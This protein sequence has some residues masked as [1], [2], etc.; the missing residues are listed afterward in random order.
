MK[1]SD[2]YYPI[3][4][5]FES[6]GC[7]VEGEVKSCDVIVKMEEE[8]LAIEMKQ[9]LNFK[10][11]LQAVQRQKMF[12]LVYIAIPIKKINQA[13]RI[14]REKIHLLK[15]L[16]LGLLL[17]EPKTVV[18][19]CVQQPIESNQRQI[20]SANKKRKE[21][22]IQEFEKRIL[23]N[24]IG[25][26]HQQKINTYYRQ[27]CCQVAYYLKEKPNSAVGLM[28][29][30]LERKR[31]HQILY[32]NHYGW[33]ER[34]E[35]RGNYQLSELGREMVKNNQEMLQKLVSESEAKTDSLET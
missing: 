32:D 16:G 34:T 17:I 3:K 10:V 4:N 7:T 18:V 35:I 19:T 28:K 30:G 26:V 25:G 23:K 6:L 20:L 1:E 33:F 13:S 27:Q 5:Y 31:T 11:I 14:F 9:E 2:L 15:R 12:D 24:N 21:K 22:V 29:M 8:Y